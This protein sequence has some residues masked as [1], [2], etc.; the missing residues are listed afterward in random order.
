MPLRI[1]L[2]RLSETPLVLV[3]VR[4][5]VAHCCFQ[6][7][8][9]ESATTGAASACSVFAKVASILFR[10]SWKRIE[11]AL[12][13]TLMASLKS[14]LRDV[15]NRRFKVVDETVDLPSPLPAA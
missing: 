3:F 11:N 10:L 12:S 8:D 1:S 2:Q 4:L 6:S 15:Q 9:L 5:P 13:I 7:V 14:P